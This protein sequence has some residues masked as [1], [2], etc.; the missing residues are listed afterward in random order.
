M[1]FNQFVTEFINNIL[2]L[3]GGWLIIGVPSVLLITF[4]L[5]VIGWVWNDITER[6]NN[7][8]FKLISVF[9]T[10]VF[11]LP[12]LVIY[13]LIRPKDTLS[14]VYWSELEKR[15]LFFET[16]ELR[17]CPKCDCELF[18][19]F[20][21]CPNCGYQVMTA[22]NSC[23]KYS[24][25]VWKFCAYC[26]AQKQAIED[27]FMT[28]EMAM[29]ARGADIAYTS[30]GEDLSAFISN[31]TKGLKERMSKSQKARKEKKERRLEAKREAQKKKEEARR[32]KEEAK[33]AAEAKNKEEANNEAQR[34]SEKESK[35]SDKSSNKS[36][37]SGMDEK[38]QEKNEKA[39]K[40]SEKAKRKEG[41]G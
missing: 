4:W 5:L 3:E 37:K 40:K 8:F 35:K 15:Y 23:Q 36:G 25:K 18:P 21:S 13:L 19:G 38:K 12:G 9:V 11:G 16:K 22:C 20:A 26:G 1:D 28:A 39:E 33:K 30:L 29:D 31:L 7:Q 32:E 17:D 24:D 27:E 6:T 34:K 14:E 41:N 2:A 10:L